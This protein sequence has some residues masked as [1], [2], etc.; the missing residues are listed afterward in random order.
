MSFI[1]STGKF[2]RYLD[3]QFWINTGNTLLPGWSVRHVVFIRLSNIVTTMASINTVIRYR[4][5]EYGRY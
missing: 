5:V 2:T 4:Q 1:R 3:N